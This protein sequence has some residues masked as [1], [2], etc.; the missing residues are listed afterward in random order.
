MARRC[1][2]PGRIERQTNRLRL[3]TAHMFGQSGSFF[4][5]GNRFGLKF[6]YRIKSNTLYLPLRCHI[7]GL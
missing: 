1:Y 7:D 4:R 2:L 6:L 5:R 3:R